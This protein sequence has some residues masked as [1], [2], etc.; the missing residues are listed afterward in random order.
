MGLAC[1]RES[2]CNWSPGAQRSGP[3]AASTT[4]GVVCPSMPERRAP[5]RCGNGCNETKRVRT[6]RILLWPL[7]LGV[8]ALAGD[9]ADNLVVCGVK[10]LEGATSAALEPIIDCEQGKA[11]LQ[12]M[13]FRTVRA[14]CRQIVNAMVCCAKRRIIARGCAVEMAALWS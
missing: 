13:P 12:S 5:G 4:L 10:L 11:R 2:S 6:K 7:R 14:D 1:S 9:H 3:V 8:V